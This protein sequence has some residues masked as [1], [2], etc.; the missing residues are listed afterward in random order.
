MIIP[1]SQRGTIGMEMQQP[2]AVG[3]GKVLMSWHDYS[4][5]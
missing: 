1:G 2:S 5:L 4:M 3:I